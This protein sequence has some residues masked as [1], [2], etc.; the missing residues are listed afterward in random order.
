[1]K[2]I[3]K[4]LIISMFFGTLFGCTKEEVK[5][6]KDAVEEKVQERTDGKD[7]KEEAEKIQEKVEE[8]IKEKTETNEEKTCTPKKFKNKYSYVYETNEECMNKGNDAFLYIADNVNSEI[9][10]YG[11]EEIVDECGKT[12]YGVY[13]NTWENN[14]AKKNY[15]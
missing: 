6:L 12:W 5:D 11:C 1:M 10:T 3:V 4:L 2:K 9:F 8:K 13:F 14:D 15:Y 7:I